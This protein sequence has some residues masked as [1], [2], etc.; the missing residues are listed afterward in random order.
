MHVTP[1][2]PIG[3][4]AS[5][6]GGL[7]AAAAGIGAAVQHRSGVPRL[8]GCRE[9][10]P[11]DCLSRVR[12]V[13]GPAA[14]PQSV[15]VPTLPAGSVGDGGD[16]LPGQQAAI[17]GVV[18]GHVAG[19]QPEERHQRVGL[20][21][22]P[23]T[24]QLQDGLG[25][26]GCVA[27]WR[28]TRRTGAAKKRGDEADGVGIGRIRLRRIPD[29]SRRTLHGFIG[30][31]IEPG[32]TV[33]TDGLQAYR[34]LQDYLHNRSVQHRQPAEAEH[35]LPRVH[36]VASLLKRWLLGTHQGAIAHA[37]LDDYL[38]EFTF[39]FNRRTSASRGKLFYRL[40]QQAVQVEP[41][42]LDALLHPKR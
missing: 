23:G 25:A 39:R 33:M 11:R 20:A 35:L 31:A 3:S 6:G 4:V 40:A 22:C 13:S 41:L 24:G 30:H 37:H 10:A 26:T 7:S 28:W 34:D 19:D 36:R 1:P 8:L 16:H 15:A 2:P 38:D 9:V 18:P 29:T 21:T 5:D 12:G 14:P 27:S 42:P 17:D 32:S